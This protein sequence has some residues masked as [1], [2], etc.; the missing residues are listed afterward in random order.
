VIVGAAVLPTAP[1]LVPG[2]TAARPPGLDRVIV[3]ARAVVAAL[4][5]HDVAVLLTPARTGLDRVIVAARSAGR[6]RRRS[7]EDGQ[8]HRLGVRR[9][10]RV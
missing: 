8:Q 4:P 9:G 7:R 3:A 2:V 5:A 6:Q 1:L 10:G